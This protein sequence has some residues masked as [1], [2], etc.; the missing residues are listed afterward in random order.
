MIK[1]FHDCIHIMKPDREIVTIM[2]NVTNFNKR[3]SSGG[4]V[5][6]TEASKAHFAKKFGSYLNSS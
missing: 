1:G 4:Y 3:V 5:P 6:L 2:N